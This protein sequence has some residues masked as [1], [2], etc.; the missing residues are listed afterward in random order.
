MWFGIGLFMLL[1][2]LSVSNMWYDVLLNSPRL[3][4]VS[5]KMLFFILDKS[6]CMVNCFILITKLNNFCMNNVRRIYIL[7]N[8]LWLKGSKLQLFY[9]KNVLFYY[10]YSIKIYADSFDMF[11]FFQG[12]CFL[13]QSSTTEPKPC[14]CPWK[15]GLCIL[16][17]RVRK[18]FYF[19]TV[20]HYISILSFFDQSFESS[21]IWVENNCR[22]QEE[23]F[24][25][26]IYFWDWSNFYVLQEEVFAD[27]NNLK[28][29][30]G[31]YFCSLTMFF[32]CHRK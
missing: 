32:F 26:L 9:F 23:N 11:L 10:K 20:F 24:A 29:L 18:C 7:I 4:L 3:P 8:W 22:Q 27:C 13:S 1:L 30:M 25:W 2:T 5:L 6:L 14:S 12:C 28:F 31:T 21:S 19:F 17:A 16:W 15:F